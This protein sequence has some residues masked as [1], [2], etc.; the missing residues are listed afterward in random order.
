ML[1]LNN[2]G[3]GMS[4]MVICTTLILCALLVA[5]FFSIRLFSQINN[6]LVVDNSLEDKQE[7]INIDDYYKMESDLG[8]SAID[9]LQTLSINL[10]D[11]SYRISYEVLKTHGFIE[12]LVDTKT[13][14]ECVGYAI[15]NNNFSY[16]SFIK[17]DSYVSEGYSD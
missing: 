8:K 16:D 7:E 10:N 13:N 6:P 15:V 17:C 3:W 4:T 12:T 5:T 2:K 9:Y 11:L 1:K 14:K